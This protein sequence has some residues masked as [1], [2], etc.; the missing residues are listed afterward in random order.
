MDPPYVL[1][2]P[3]IMFS[4]TTV[5]CPPPLYTAAYYDGSYYSSIHVALDTVYRPPSV[6]QERA[7]F[8]NQTI[9]F[10]NVS[11]IVMSWKIFKSGLHP[12]PSP[13]VRVGTK[14][15]L[16]RIPNHTGHVVSTTQGHFQFSSRADLTSRSS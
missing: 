10:S 3:A 14:R 2:T 5:F 8:W 13:T 6:F 15:V 4:T 7:I 1:S 9:G 11:V 12:T 16:V